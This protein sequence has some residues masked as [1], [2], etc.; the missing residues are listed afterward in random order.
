MPT[1]EADHPRVTAS[2]ATNTSYASDLHENHKT[3]WMHPIRI[4]DD[5]GRING[6]KVVE[7][8][9]PTRQYPPPAAKQPLLSISGTKK[10]TG[11]DQ[12][13]MNRSMGFGRVRRVLRL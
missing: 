12:Q 4:G 10:Q 7:R 13:L 11:L 1:R 2:F 5:L 9:R 8:L 3:V 6:P